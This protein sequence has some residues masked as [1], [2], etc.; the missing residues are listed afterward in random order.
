MASPSWY[1]LWIVDSVLYQTLPPPPSRLPWQFY[2]THLYPWE[3]NGTVRVRCLAEELNKMTHTHGLNLECSFQTLFSESIT[4]PLRLRLCS[5][6]LF[7]LIFYFCWRFALLRYDHHVCIDLT[8]EDS[9]LYSLHGVKNKVGEMRY[10]GGS[11]LT[12][13]AL[14]EVKDKIFKGAPRHGVPR[15]CI[16][17]TDGITHGGSLAVK[18]PSSYL[19][20]GLSTMRVPLHILL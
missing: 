11:T 10:T 9:V 12:H 16:L 8:L 19:R 18:Q 6:T 7:I 5:H 15:T 17:M 13:L 2:G 14:K 20:V 4:W 1:S 3:V